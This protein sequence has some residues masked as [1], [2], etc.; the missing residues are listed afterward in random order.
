MRHTSKLCTGSSMLAWRSEPPL[1]LMPRVVGK[2]FSRMLA[3]PGLSMAGLCDWIQPL[4]GAGKLLGRA[5]AVALETERRR[6]R[7]IRARWREDKRPGREDAC[8]R[9]AG[10][11]NP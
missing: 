4:T 3:P 2:K 6:K 10:C 1:G 8:G 5:R 11:A 9:G 7:G